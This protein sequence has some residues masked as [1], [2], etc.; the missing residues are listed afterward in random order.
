M[1][2]RYSIEDYLE[3]EST[4]LTKHEYWNGKIWEMLGRSDVHNEIYACI[5]IL[6]GRTHLGLTLI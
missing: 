4:S 3:M 1:T 5:I 2:N 6:S